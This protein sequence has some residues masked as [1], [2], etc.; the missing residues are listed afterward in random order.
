M[1]ITFV[2]AVWLPSVGGMEVLTGQVLA[3]LRERGHQ[4][5]MVTT[6]H[7]TSLPEHEI[8]DGIEVVRIDALDAI[9]RRDFPAILKAQRRT[10]EIVQGLRPDVLHAHDGPPALWMYL[11]AARDHRPPLLLTLHS[12]MSRHFS[13]T[14]AA[15]DGLRTI[16]RAADR[17]SGVSSAIVDDAIAIED[18]IATRAVIVPNGVRPFDRAWTPVSDR[19]DELL[20]LGRLAPEKNFGR[21]IGALRLLAEHRPGVRLTI[22]GDGDERE[23]LQRTA[24]RLGVDDRVEFVGMVDHSRIPELLDR[25]TLVVMP[26]AYEGMPLVALEAAWMA[27]PV[28]AAAVPG[29]EGVIVDGVTGRIVDGDDEALADAIGQLLDDRNLVRS[30]GAAARARAESQFSLAACVD[31]YEAIYAELVSGSSTDGPQ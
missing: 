1:R 23:S 16:L 29:L 30:M 4:V 27:R 5:S 12:V 15:L 8:V 19:V 9:G 28:V 10:W 13:A 18:S 2:T 17:I 11:R 7:S 24:R 6:R 25:A 14:G 22:V 21:A 31:R 3:E 26:S 20:C